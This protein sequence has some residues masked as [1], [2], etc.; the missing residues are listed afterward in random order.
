MIIYSHKKYSLN[1]LMFQYIDLRI[2]HLFFHFVYKFIYIYIDAP[3]IFFIPLTE[4]KPNYL[5]ILEMYIIQYWR[6]YT[7]FL[8]TLIL[9][10]L[11]DFFTLLFLF[12][13]FLVLYIESTIYFFYSSYPIQRELFDYFKNLYH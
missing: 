2:Q 5:I 10:F 7:S 12:I 3:F 1:I 9:D 8:N 11:S 4:P 6:Y 13:Y